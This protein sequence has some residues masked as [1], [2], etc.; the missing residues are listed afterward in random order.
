MQ[1][2]LI[3]TT[4]RQFLLILGVFKSFSFANFLFGKKCASTE[5]YAFWVFLFYANDN[6]VELCKIGLPYYSSFPPSRALP[7]HNGR[8]KVGPGNNYCNGVVWPI[9]AAGLF[10]IFEWEFIFTFWGILIVFG[11]GE[12]GD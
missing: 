10:I 12:N 11:G 7:L 1:S 3:F 8:M 5:I 2:L 6:L 4:F 9:E